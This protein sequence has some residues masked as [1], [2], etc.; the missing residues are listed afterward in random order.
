MSAANPIR[1]LVARS[2]VKVS[3]KVVVEIQQ[4]LVEDVGRIL[5]KALAVT[6]LRKGRRNGGR[7]IEVADVRYAIALRRPEGCGMIE[8]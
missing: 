7:R 4:M 3:T 5:L 8:F 2:G 6:E 1:N